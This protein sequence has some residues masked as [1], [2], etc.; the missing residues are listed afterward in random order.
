MVDVLMNPK[1]HFF[2][3]INCLC[4][5]ICFRS[6]CCPLISAK[7]SQIKK[8]SCQYCPKPHFSRAFPHFWRAVYIQTGI[9]LF[10]F[11]YTHTHTHTHTLTHSLAHS[12]SHTLS[13]THTHTHTHTQRAARSPWKH[14]K[15]N[16]R[17][18]LWVSHY[19]RITF[20]SASVPSWQWIQL[21]CH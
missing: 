17:W 18:S 6:L 10:F 5:K 13:L 11:S 4:N 19:E 14:I 20:I 8:D 15:Q 12:L 2:L 9:Y 16:E 7:L 1:F 3:C 21:W